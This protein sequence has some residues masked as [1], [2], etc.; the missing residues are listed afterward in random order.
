MAIALIANAVA[1]YTSASSGATTDARDTTGAN[2]ICVSFNCYQTGGTFS[3]NKGNTSWTEITAY[4]ANNQPRVRT[5]YCVNPTV[6]SGHTFTLS[7]SNLY[8]TIQMSAWSGV[9]T[10]DPLEAQNGSSTTSGGSSRNSGTVSPANDGALILAHYAGFANPPSF[11]GSPSFT[12]LTAFAGVGSVYFSTGGAYYIQPTAG[13]IN[14]GWSWPAI[15]SG[16]LGNHVAQIVAFNAA[17]PT[18]IEGSASITEAGDTASGTGTLD[19]SGAA[20]MGEAGDTLSATGEGLGEISGSADLAEDDDTASASGELPISGATDATEAGDSLSGSGSLPIEGAAA[21]AEGGDTV[22]AT[23]IDPDFPVHYIGSSTNAA[24]QTVY[25][26]ADQPIGEASA[27]RVVVVIAHGRGDG[28]ADLKV[29]G[30]TVGGSA[31]AQFFDFAQIQAYHAGIWFIEIASGTTADIVVTFDGPSE[32]CKTDVYALTGLASSTPLE[33]GV[34]EEL[35][36]GGLLDATVGGVAIAC[37]TADSFSDFSGVVAT[38][39]N[40]T[41]EGHAA[42]C[43]SGIMTETDITYVDGYPYVTVE[44]NGVTSSGYLMMASWDVLSTVDAIAEITEA[45]DSAAASAG[46]SIAGATD[47]VETGDTL[48][49]TGEGTSI[50]GAAAITEDDDS[51]AASAVL[52]LEG[53]ASIT[54]AG[55]SLSGAGVLPATGAASI[56]EG[57]DEASATGAVPIAG[58]LSGTDDDDTLTAEAASALSGAAVVT[59]AGDMLS[60]SGVLPIAGA[61]DAGEEGDTLAGAAALPID[62]AL[63]AGEADDTLDAA[64]G[65]PSA[66]GSA[67]ITEGDDLLASTSRLAIAGAVGLSEAGDTLGAAA[68]A[69]VPAVQYIGSTSNTGDLTT[70]TFSGHAIGAARA[71]RTIVVVV[72]AYGAAAAARTVSSLTIAGNAATAVINPSAAYHCSIWR[73]AVPTGSTADIVA[74]FSGGCEWCRI[75]VYALARLASPTPTDSD[76]DTGAVLTVDLTTTAGGVVIAG[77]TSDTFTG[78]SAGVSTDDNTTVESRQ[79]S[80]GHGTATGTTTTVTG[81][82]VTSL[83]RLV[84]ASWAVLPVLAATTSITEA[85]DSVTGAGELDIAGAATIT[86]GDDTLGGAGALPITGAGAITEAGDT[87]SANDFPILSADAD[88][89]EDNDSVLSIATLP[90]SGAL[91]ATEAGDTLSAAGQFVIPAIVPPERTLIFTASKLDARTLTFATSRLSARTLSFPT[92]RQSGRTIDLE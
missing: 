39:S 41:V 10:A 17:A 2:F 62:G 9:D 16:G 19:I 26:F 35:G 30:L 52:P 55:D 72:H 22:S 32:W 49:A 70:Y 23:G 86:E 74:T 92:S 3:D 80:S 87:L 28:G 54:E 1:H 50:E 57:D 15:L 47:L 75:D 90:L 79:S 82:G 48:A 67:A 4:N 78:Y 5:F 91:D 63:E 46:L 43:G 83:S 12:T 38:D 31:A 11:S 66:Q 25:T 71:D 65:L 59:E 89:A 84:A 53:S 61:L 73:L 14:S 42:A 69:P 13:S 8:G 37:I 51:L 18:S 56:T 45:D 44:S 58:A 21:L 34:S 60:G 68:T 77:A 88:I 36:Q 7:G 6:G 76:T 40:T 20:S 81:T 85:G 24:N 33:V 27:D 29:S 64:G